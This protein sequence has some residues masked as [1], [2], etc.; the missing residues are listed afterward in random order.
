MHGWTESHS[1]LNE[2]AAKL[3]N[4][5]SDDCPVFARP[6][7]NVPPPVYNRPNQ[8]PP[9]YGASMNSSAQSM[10]PQ[11]SPMTTTR[12]NISS[13]VAAASQARPAQEDIYD[14]RR[15]VSNRL[16]TRMTEYLKDARKE[17]ETE[18]VAQEKLKASSHDTTQSMDSIQNQIYR[19]K[20]IRND[21][22][23]YND[24]LEQWIVTV[25][26]NAPSSAAAAGNGKSMEEDEEFL[27]SC[28]VPTD[29]CSRQLFEVVAESNAIED[30][31][32]QMDN[33]VGKLEGMDLK[34][35]LKEVRELNRRLFFANALGL[36]LME[37]QQTAIAPPKNANTSPPPPPFQQANAGFIQPY[38][39]S[40]GRR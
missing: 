15:K 25:E 9:L 22:V 39:S 11:P 38:P 17:L 31:L 40:F 32:Y 1:N 35:Y 5:F 28:V 8:P 13:N 24:Q 10:Y 37:V 23:H 4:V 2:L 30:T 33:T 7:G 14:K 16:K 6:P 21:L 18:T 19:I 27:D 36:K 20:T 3:I 34:S 29:T 12:P 26:S